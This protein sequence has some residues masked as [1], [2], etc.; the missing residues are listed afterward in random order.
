MEQPLITSQIY[1]LL[2][3]GIILQTYESL[4]K[5]KN[6]RRAIH[7]PERVGCAAESQKDHSGGSGKGFAGLLL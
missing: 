7:K 2:Y 4:V 3:P 5:M 1:G 6:P